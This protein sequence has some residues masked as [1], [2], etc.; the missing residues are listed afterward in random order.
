[1]QQINI[2]PQQIHPRFRFMTYHASIDDRIN[3]HKDD[4]TL[5]DWFN[6]LKDDELTTMDEQIHEDADK[7]TRLYLQTNPNVTQ[8]DYDRIYYQKYETIFL[9]R[10][11]KNKDKLPKFDY[12]FYGETGRDKVKLSVLIKKFMEWAKINEIPKSKYLFIWS[13][14][15]LE[16]AAHRLYMNRLGLIQNKL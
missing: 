5:Q 11:N 16:G 4:D 2:I 3:N 1:M 10:T 15:I 6:E 7:L 8:N 12:K 13:S 14:Q 9:K